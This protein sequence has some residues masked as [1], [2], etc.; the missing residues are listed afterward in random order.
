MSEKLT[1]TK[2]LISDLLSFKKIARHTE[3]STQNI[4]LLDS[5]RHL[6]I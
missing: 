4:A 6:Q 3:K 1:F 2:G 5:E